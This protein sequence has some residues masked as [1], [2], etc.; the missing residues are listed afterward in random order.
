MGK[1]ISKLTKVGLQMEATRGTIPD[2]TAGVS[3]G[4][5]WTEMT[6]DR[7]VKTVENVS[8][9]G[10]V[11]SAKDMSV[12]QYFVEGSLKTLLTSKTLPRLGLWISGDIL[13]SGTAPD[14]T[15]KNRLYYNGT[16]SLG[17]TVPLHR[18]FTIYENDH[19]MTPNYYAYPNAMVDTAELAFAVGE[20]P[21]LTTTFKA[22]YPMSATPTDRDI[23]P[24]E[25]DT[26]ATAAYM[27]ISLQNPDGTGSVDVCTKAFTLTISKNLEDDFCIGAGDSQDYLNKTLSVEG[28]MEL[29]WQD[30][31]FENLLDGDT[32]KRIELAIDLGN[33]KWI[34]IS[35]PR[36]KLKEVAKSRAIDDYI[37]Q[38]VSFKAFASDIGLTPERVYE[39]TTE[40]DVE[41]YTI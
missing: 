30:D 1:Y 13:T 11:Y 15:H 22:R 25:D 16:S 12:T 14:F 2:G 32:A 5:P 41:D 34:R 19:S 18:S 38:T 40:N 33:T 31:T 7:K 26:L 17:D 3:Y 10:D 24:P 21:T 28:S 23:T 29:L 39:I 37:R 8:S 6:L 35:L 20:Y 9:Y 36:V 4:I 27:T